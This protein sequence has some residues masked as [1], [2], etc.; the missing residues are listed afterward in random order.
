VNSWTYEL[1]VGKGRRF[2]PA[3]P[4]NWVLGGWKIS[5][6]AEFSKGG[7]QAVYVGTDNSGTAQS[8]AMADRICNPDSV[9]GG[10]N[11][12]QWFNTACFPT[13]AFGAYGNSPLGVFVEPGINNWKLSLLK[14]FPAL[15]TETHRLDFRA[16][17]FNA[18]NHTQWGY[19]NNLNLP[20]S[21]SSGR[22]GAAHTAR[23]VEFS[24]KYAF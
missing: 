12:L 15:K 6:T 21:F 19:V 13:P 24:L 20:S 2:Q 16:D 9:P 14:S 18:F 4:F 3:G 11:R 17:F 22:V 8:Y 1:P 10:R 5:G 7:H 23:Q